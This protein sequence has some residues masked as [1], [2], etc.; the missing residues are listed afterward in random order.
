MIKAAMTNPYAL[1][2]EGE[3]TN[4]LFGEGLEL[5]HVRKPKYSKADMRAFIESI[6][7]KYHNRLI[8]HHD[9]GLAADYQLR[10]VHLSPGDRN[11]L[12][13]MKI[14][15]P[16]LRKKHPELQLSS[17]YA[18]PRI[19]KSIPY[20]LSHV[21]LGPAYGVQPNPEIMFQKS[22]SEVK[23]HLAKSKIPILALGGLSSETLPYVRKAGFDGACLQRVI[24][25]S[26]DPKRSYI[27]CC[28]ILDS[29]PDLESSKA[30]KIE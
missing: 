11:S 8:L 2:N 12:W 21:L 23:A 4:A 10:G 17:T 1:M 26:V 18:K 6:D 22:I 5:L 30:K 27:Q 25:K 14:L 7:K 29:A 16:L 28:E 3:K 15:I 20:N 13:V 19:L 9:F 24:W